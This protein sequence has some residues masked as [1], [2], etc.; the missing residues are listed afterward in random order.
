MG[1]I[2][3]YATVVIKDGVSVTIKQFVDTTEA[4]LVYQTALNAGKD[5][6]YYFCP[7]KRKSAF[8]NPAP[9]NVTY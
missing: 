5:A 1:Y 4:R 6:Y 3:K 7:R 8:D 9:I 2:P